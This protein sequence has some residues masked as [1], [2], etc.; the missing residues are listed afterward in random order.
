MQSTRR[1]NSR[2]EPSESTNTLDA[3]CAQFLL[4]AGSTNAVIQAFYDDPRVTRL[5]KHACGKFRL[6]DAT[7]DEIKQDL[8]ILLDGKFLNRLEHPEKIY[9]VLHV[10]AL[11]LARRRHDKFSEDSLDELIERGGESFTSS[12]PALVDHLSDRDLADDQLDRSRAKA[13][14]SRR[15]KLSENN[16]TT[17]TDEEGIG[18]MN[19]SHT[20]VASFGMSFF[21]PKPVVVYRQP[22]PPR[23][24]RTNELSAEAIELNEIRQYLGY[25]VPEFAKLMN[26]RKGTLSSYLYG[27][28]RSIPLALMT[29]ARALRKQGGQNFQES[30]A[31]F[32]DM[33]M[34][35]IVE[36]WETKLA[37]G[38]APAANGE[39][40]LGDVLGVDRATVWRWKERDMRPDLRKLREYDEIIT[41]YL[42]K[43]AG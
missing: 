37:G 33:K 14:F 30:A 23:P 24:E 38:Q 26:T 20:A 36:Q 10:T 15:L 5:A 13:E 1:V 27:T 8:A 34:T 6:P 22:R 32:N 19:L 35:E 31:K 4:G 7:Y 41:R 3:A 18:T 28:V 17:A 25:T 40:E 21:D 9:N 43:H 11:N 12:S 39:T 29:E 2:I 42:K 16:K